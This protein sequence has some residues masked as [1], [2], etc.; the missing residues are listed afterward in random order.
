M[1]RLFITLAIA[2]GLLAPA[3]VTFSSASVY[4]DAFSSSNAKNQ[5]CTGIS[6]EEDSLK[7]CTAPTKS[8]NAII[9]AVLNFLSAIVGVVA[10]I[11][12]IVSGFKYITAAGD[13]GKASNARSTLTYA[14]IGVVIAALA[15][16]LVQF[17]LK[18]VSK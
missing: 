15:Q 11:M 8:I 6:G 2:L 16:A 9:I 7:G 3:V 17:V 10:V 5:A 13:S 18:K 4:A 14:V 12:V 1:K